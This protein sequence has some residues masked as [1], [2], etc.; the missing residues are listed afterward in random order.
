MK[1]ISRLLVDRAFGRV[2]REDYVAWA[3]D[4]LLAGVESP[5]LEVLA[6]LDPAEWS[7]VDEYFAKSCAD[8]GVPITQS[9]AGSLE[10]A[11]LLRSLYAEGDLPPETLIAE[12]GELHS[13]HLQTNLFLPWASLQAEIESRHPTSQAWWPKGLFYPADALDDLRSSIEREWQIFDLMIA[14]PRFPEL[15]TWVYCRT[16]S[17]RGVPQPEVRS[18]D[19]QIDLNPGVQCAACGSSDVFAVGRDPAF[20]LTWLLAHGGGVEEPSNSA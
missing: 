19:W 18:L 9:D 3:V 12:M 7:E 6:G 10:V 15:P 4:A 17:S 5:N 14:Y 13:R 20:R 2:N 16:C 11:A 1:E 8:L